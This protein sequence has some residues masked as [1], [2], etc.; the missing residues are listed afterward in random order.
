V[1]ANVALRSGS[2]QHGNARRAEVGYITNDN[3]DQCAQVEYPPIKSM[4]GPLSGILQRTHLKMSE[5]II[6]LLPLFLPSRYIVPC[7]TARKLTGILDL[8]FGFAPRWEL[9][10]ERVRRPFLSVV[11]G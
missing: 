10:L 4:V 1:I 8:Q 11:G 5:R 2:S 6:V 9:L 3:D 7:H